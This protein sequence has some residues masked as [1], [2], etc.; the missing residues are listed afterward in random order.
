MSEQHSHYCEGC[1][2]YWLHDCD[3]C[4]PV[5]VRYSDASDAICPQCDGAEKFTGSP[6]LDAD[7]V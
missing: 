6:L 1:G 4:L 3:L 7:E 2:C 5:D